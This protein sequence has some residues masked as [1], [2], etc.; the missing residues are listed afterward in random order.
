[1]PEVHVGAG[2]AIPPPS[3]I[4]DPA[5]SSAPPSL[6]A[7][8]AKRAVK[9]RGAA[10]YSGFGADSDDDGDK[11]LRSSAGDAWKEEEAEK[12]AYRRSSS[13]DR[14]FRSVRAPGFVAGKP[15]ERWQEM[16]VAKDSK[17]RRKSRSRSRKGARKKSRSRS[18]KKSRSRSRRKD[19]SR[20]RSRRKDFHRKDSSQKKERSR[21]R[22]K[23]KRSRSRSKSN[24][25]KR[26]RSRSKKSK[27]RRRSAKSKSKSRSK[28]RAKDEKSKHGNKRGRSSSSSSSSRSKEKGA[29]EKYKP[30]SRVLLRNLVKN[31]EL[32]AQAGV[33]VP[34]SCAQSPEV[35][36]CLK[37]RL[38]SGREVAVKPE[39]LHIV[40]AAPDEKSEPDGVVA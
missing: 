13:R 38:E 15:W 37:V 40:Q 31:Y 11:T 8:V 20:S 21:S 32:N 1:M 29:L 24:K 34:A 12:L 19:R 17:S 5:T 4:N 3:G 16:N 30:Y 22:N 2:V 6:E 28:G 18:R 23:R 10:R 14:Q 27:E 39:N 7:P 33:I 35:P 9:G 36:G 26:S 25:K